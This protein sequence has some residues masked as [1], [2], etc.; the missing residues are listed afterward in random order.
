MKIVFNFCV[1]IVSEQQQ[2]QQRTKMFHH[3][4]QWNSLLISWFLFTFYDM[5]ALI[6]SAYL[7]FFQYKKWNA[8]KSRSGVWIWEFKIEIKIFGRCEVR[9]RH[10]NEWEGGGKEETPVSRESKANS[11]WKIEKRLPN[12]WAN[13]NLCVYFSMVNNGLPYS[14][15]IYGCER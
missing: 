2:Q 5:E 8:R 9:E 10:S 13:A 4:L 6:S 15:L 14:F 3:K 1:Q 11:D 12:W 7:F